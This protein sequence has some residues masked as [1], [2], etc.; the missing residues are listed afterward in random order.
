M[1]ARVWNIIFLVGFIIYCWIR[2][3]YQ[4]RTRANERI[5]RRFDRLERNL[6]FWVFLGNVVLPVI[7]VL[8]PWLAF[9]DY[10]LPRWVPWWGLGVMVLALWLF[11]RSHAD[12]GQN[13]SIT[14]E[15]RKN[16]ELIRHG[17]YRTMRHPMYSS[18]FLFGLAQ[19]LMLNN[20][21]AGWSAVIT[22]VPLYFLRTPREER[23]MLEQF[24]DDYRA[25]MGET[26]RL[27][28]RVGMKREREEVEEVMR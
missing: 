25:Y 18:I 2:G 16:H 22:F 24:G 27:W 10:R 26:G 3:V 12:L 19:G 13:W 8:T 9:A 1:S 21:L 4:R 14:L 15:I 5:V 6:M 11:W 23:M 28:P 20:W 17:V 7:Y